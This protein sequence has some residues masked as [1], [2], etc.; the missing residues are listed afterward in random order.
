M[1]FPVKD[2]EIKEDHTL[3]NCGNCRNWNAREGKCLKNHEGYYKYQAHTCCDDF[4]WLDS[5]T[6]SIRQTMDK[7]YTLAAKPR[8]VHEEYVMTESPT[9][10]FDLPLTCTAKGGVKVYV[11]Y[12]MLQ[13]QVHFVVNGDKVTINE[14]ACVLLSVGDK[15]SIDY[16]T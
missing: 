3:S 5:S 14:N 7:Y 12:T 1:Y 15:I 13:D 10:R 2:H 8:Q 9:C 11:N 16:I 6:Q 4:K